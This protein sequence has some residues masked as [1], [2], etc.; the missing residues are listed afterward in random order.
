MSTSLAACFVDEKIENFE[1]YF[2][3][4]FKVLK[5]L[6]P[7][8][9]F[10]I[11]QFYQISSFKCFE[12]KAFYVVLYDDHEAERRTYMLPKLNRCV[13]IFPLTLTSQQTLNTVV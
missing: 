1:A 13:G 7:M 2:G 6:L 8:I 10:L 11:W 12:F 5:F 3:K 9:F 4:L